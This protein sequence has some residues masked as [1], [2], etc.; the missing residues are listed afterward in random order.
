MGV[1]KQQGK[2]EAV[3]AVA[4]PEPAATATTESKNQLNIA[5]RYAGTSA[6]TLFTL[7]GAIQFLTPEQVAQLATASHDLSNSI[8][9][10]YGALLKMWV[11]LGPV[12]VGG[13]AVVGFKS[14]SIKS[15]GEK[16][17]TLSHGPSGNTELAKQSLIAATVSL[18]SVKTI[19]TD[20][21][22][23]AAAP[24]DAVIPEEKVKITK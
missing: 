21:E 12:V 5:L 15:M 19:V 17:L 14:G 24:S 8:I 10:G 13:L 2:A 22:T 23:A 20:K 16:L 4:T 6:G 11:I 1:D 7:L 3:A 18:P 9:T